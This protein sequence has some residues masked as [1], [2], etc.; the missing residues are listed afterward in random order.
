[1]AI[2]IRKEKEL[3]KLHSMMMYIVQLR[4]DVV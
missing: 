1:M 2:V 3:D 4:C